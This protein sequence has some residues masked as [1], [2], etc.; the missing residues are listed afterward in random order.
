MIVLCM[1]GL[2]EISVLKHSVVESGV[3]GY[4][5]ITVNCVSMTE[6][7]SPITVDISWIN[8][9]HTGL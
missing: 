9:H 4:A 5:Y 8:N 7:D 3:H 6:H 2:G 1:H